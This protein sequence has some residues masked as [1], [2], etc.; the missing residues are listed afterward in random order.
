PRARSQR[1]VARS[2]VCAFSACR[3]C[4]SGCQH[5]SLRR[6]RRIHR[7]A[8]AGTVHHGQPGGAVVGGLIVWVLTPPGSVTIGASGLVFAY[9]GWLIARA[10][11]ER[12]VV[13]I[14]IGLVAL[15]L[16]G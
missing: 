6:A 5:G 9:F 7:A 13:A 8:I 2:V 1:V 12:S 15:V 11:R 3:T 10:V 4:S 16:Y 14:G